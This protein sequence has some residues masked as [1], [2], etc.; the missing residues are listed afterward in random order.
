MKEET[1]MK[2]IELKTQRLCILEKK[3]FTRTGLDDREIT[4]LKKEIS[5]LEKQLK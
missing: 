4:K 5:K 1:I 2:L 3:H